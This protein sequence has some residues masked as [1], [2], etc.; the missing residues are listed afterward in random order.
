VL[1][2]DAALLSLVEPAVL[3]SAVCADSL[4]LRRA[5]TAGMEAIDHLWEW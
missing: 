5:L 2:D 1:S 4:D 3:I